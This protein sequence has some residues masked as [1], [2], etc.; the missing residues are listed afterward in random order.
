MNG[1]LSAG[2]DASGLAGPEI[3]VLGL[4]KTYAGGVEA[5]RGIDFQVG[6][7]ER[8]LLLGTEPLA[9]TDKGRRQLQH[10]LRR[11]F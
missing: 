10:A 1:S 9:I 6:A 3:E 2:A 8:G 4:A 5:V 11:R 7:G